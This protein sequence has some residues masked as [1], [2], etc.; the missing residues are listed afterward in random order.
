MGGVQGDHTQYEYI[1]M[2]TDRSVSGCCQTMMIDDCHRVVK[3]HRMPY[4]YR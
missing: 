2:C 1:N 3:T 4:M